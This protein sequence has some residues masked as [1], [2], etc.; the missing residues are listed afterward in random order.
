MPLPQGLSGSLAH[1]F[2]WNSSSTTTK[3]SCTSPIFS[4]AISTQTT[5]QVLFPNIESSPGG[6]AISRVR[7]EG[8]DGAEKEREASATLE[9]SRRITAVIVK[10]TPRDRPSGPT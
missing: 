10:E 9:V 8:K 6:W 5:P 1:T 3:N 2:H 4:I 7:E